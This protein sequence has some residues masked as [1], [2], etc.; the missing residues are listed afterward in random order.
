MRT[1]GITLAFALCGLLGQLAHANPYSSRQYYSGWNY[2]KTKSYYYRTYYYK[3]KKDYYGW[4]HNYMT[5]YPRQPKYAKHYYYYNPYKKTYWGRVPTSCGGEPQY[6]IL[7]PMDR[8]EEL[9]DI[10]E[11]AFKK[12]DKMP[13]IPESTDSVPMDLPPD[14]VPPPVAVD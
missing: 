10:P 6:E 3:P 14:D 9:K 7:E 11:P 1:L 13:P 2:N 8:K 5:Y 4:K 12:M